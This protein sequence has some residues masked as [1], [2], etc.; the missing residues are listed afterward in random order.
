[1]A[2]SSI[3]HSSPS[4]P[5]TRRAHADTLLGALDE[6][7]ERF[8]DDPFLIFGA[9]ATTF[10][11]LRA[12]AVD[13]AAG[14]LGHGVAA[15]DRVAFMSTNRPELITLTF[16][17]AYAGMITVPI[18]V[19]LKGEFLRHQLVNSAASAIAVD[20]TGLAA[21]APLLDGL[22]EL[23]LIILLE[24]GL[25]VSGFGGRV[26]RYRD[27]FDVGALAEPR[28]ARPLDILLI[29]YTSGTT[30]ASKGCM[31][32]QAYLVRVAHVMSR[33]LV[34]GDDDIQLCVH[35]MFHMSGQMDLALALVSGTPIGLEPRFSASA[36][37]PRAK[38]L[39]ATYWGG[40]GISDFLLGQPAT[41]DH[42]L[43]RWIGIPFSP[44]SEAT[45]L[46]KFGIRSICQMYAQTEAN[47]V[48][49]VGLDLP[50]ARDTD[51]HVV[52]DIECQVVDDEDRPVPAG[53]VGEIVLRPR[54]PGAMFSGYWN[55]AERNIECWRNLWHHTGDLGRID[56]AGQLTFVDRKKDSMRRKGENISA[57]EL[58]RALLGYP[59]IAEVAA[60]GVRQDGALEEDI[61]ACLVLHPGETFDQRAF[62]DYVTTHVPHF[63]VI[64]Y[65]E[66]LA[67]LPRNPIGRV[68]KFE[69]RDRPNT[70]G[71]IDLF[72]LGLTSD[73]RRR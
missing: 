22:P 31:L 39:G 68:L 2:A 56:A 65:V 69:L 57:M 5:T 36:F 48:A 3:L 24:P 40:P 41:R 17:G 20:E 45:L 13:L 50:A 29:L 33:M 54:V 51:G 26:I 32:S 27:L 46:A 18:N 53:E 72:A 7:A 34:L 19:F 47:P 70:P 10:G 61:K 55:D 43:R 60:H 23:R 44:E 59:P 16:G 63:A 25:S 49:T 12:T 11:Q 4:V 64:R 52:D 38:Q 9:E 42:R 58:E 28:R 14:L 67:A 37:F 21:L 8:P 1:M 62:A 6:Q 71:T 30:G 35:P 73:R 15:G 66:V